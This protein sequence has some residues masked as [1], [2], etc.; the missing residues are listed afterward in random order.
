ML[1]LYV[2]ICDWFVYS[3]VYLDDLLWDKLFCFLADMKGIDFFFGGGGAVGG[4]IIVLIK[5]KQ[6][7]AALCTRYRYLC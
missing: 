4:T 2:L 5:R 7:L 3:V 1:R 6:H